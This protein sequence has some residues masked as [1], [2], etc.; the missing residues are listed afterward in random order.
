MLEPSA[1]VSLSDL[2]R[3]LRQGGNTHMSNG[4]CGGTPFHLAATSSVDDFIC[5]AKNTG[6]ERNTLLCQMRMIQ[7]TLNNARRQ[8]TSSEQKHE[9]ATKESDR[10]NKQ[11]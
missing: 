6:Q 3:L 9:A 10:V 8:V 11:L 4:G 1:D 5:R 2:G 7:D